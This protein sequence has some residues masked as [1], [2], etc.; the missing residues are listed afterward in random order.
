MIKIDKS[1]RSIISKIAKNRQIE[2]KNLTFKQKCL[3]EELGK[4]SVESMIYATFCTEE[5]HCNLQLLAQ[6][7]FSTF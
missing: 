2:S 1:G 7:R 5:T 3:A 6:C 4:K